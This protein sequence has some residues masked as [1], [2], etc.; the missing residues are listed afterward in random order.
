MTKTVTGDTSGPPTSGNWLSGSGPLSRAGERAGAAAL[1]ADGR[2]GLKAGVE[3][4]ADGRVGRVESGE[5]ERAGEQEGVGG[6]HGGPRV[7][8]SGEYNP[9]SPAGP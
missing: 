4:H 9:S 7:G 8:G 1:G 6:G 3:V 5:A 2:G